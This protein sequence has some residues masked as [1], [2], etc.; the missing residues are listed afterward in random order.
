MKVP[1]EGQKIYL[2]QNKKVNETR[3]C[4]EHTEACSIMQTNL[5]ITH[6]EKAMY[7]KYLFA[8][9]NQTLKGNSYTV[10]M[11]PNVKN[12][13]PYGRGTRGGGSGCEESCNLVIL[14]HSLLDCRCA[15]STLQGSLVVHMIAHI[16]FA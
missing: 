8:V 13:G 14:V 11:K 3:I 2:H 7:S 10:P 5:L 16:R 1:L 4:I 9:E 6:M 15:P 12:S